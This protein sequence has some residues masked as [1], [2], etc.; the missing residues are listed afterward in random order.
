MPKV[1]GNVMTFDALPLGS[2]AVMQQLRR[3]IATGSKTV[4]VCSRL[5]PLA[6]LRR[7]LLQ[8]SVV[9]DEE[10][11]PEDQEFILTRFQ[12]EPQFL[13]LLYRGIYRG[14]AYALRLAPAHFMEAKRCGE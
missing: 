11:L 13:V 5:E 7:R 3:R 9:V 14:P 10:M 12:R 8:Q 4:V 2:A 1:K 6:D